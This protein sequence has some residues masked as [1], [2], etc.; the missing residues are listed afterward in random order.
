MKKTLT[1]AALVAVVALAFTSCKKEYT[2]SCTAN[3]SVMGFNYPANSQ[4]TIKDTKKNAENACDDA[5]AN[6][7]TQLAGFGTGSCT[8]SKK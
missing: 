5:E 8:L 1:S 3:V 4:T 7:N 6:L 2:C